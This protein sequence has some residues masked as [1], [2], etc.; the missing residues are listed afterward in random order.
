MTEH[1]LAL[2]IAQL[3][4]GQWHFARLDFELAGAWTLSTV[5]VT[6]VVT[7]DIAAERASQAA[8]RLSS[9]ACK[10]FQRVHGCAGTSPTQGQRPKP[11]PPQG[12]SGKTK[13]P[14]T[15]QGEYL[16]WLSEEESEDDEDGIGGVG[17]GPDEAKQQVACTQE[18]TLNP[19]AEDLETQPP[20]NAAGPGCP[21]RSGLP[22][23][24][25]KVGEY[26]KLVYDELHDSLGAH[27]AKHGMSVCR[28]NRICSKRPVGVPGCLADGCGEARGNCKS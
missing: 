11:R 4:I 16:Q 22:W 25:F 15:A 23:G 28:I 13:R 3:S 20:Q 24:Q 7:V 5:T 1:D 27:C 26:G 21:A 12:S 8:N 2:H 10:L 19:A 14:Q 18:E 17:D 9:K 6:C